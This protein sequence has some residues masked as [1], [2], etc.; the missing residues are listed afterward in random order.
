M[1]GDGSHGKTL[2]ATKHPGEGI[3]RRDLLLSG[4]SLIAA[5]ALMTTSPTGLAK[6]ELLEYPPGAA[7]PGRMGRTIGESSPAWPA[8]VRAKPCTQCAFYSH[9]R[10][11]L[12]AVR[13]LRVT[14]QHAKH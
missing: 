3:K 8:P 11:W 6:A 4:T 7:F 9:R 14:G 1:N 12:W 13:L 2:P 5:S 10:H